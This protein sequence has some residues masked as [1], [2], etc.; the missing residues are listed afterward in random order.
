MRAVGLVWLCI[1]AAVVGC[2]AGQRPLIERMQDESP[3][4]RA[5]AAVQAGKRGNRKA[6]PFLIDRLTDQDRTV[7]M[8]AII[9]LEKMT[10]RTLGYRTSAPSAE[11]VSAAR[12]W[13]RWWRK[14]VQQAQ[15]QPAGKAVQ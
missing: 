5:K 4:V 10:G 8:F 6:I 12:R 1:I 13:R 15:S 14:Q 11:Q 9:S 2:D 3:V 7:R